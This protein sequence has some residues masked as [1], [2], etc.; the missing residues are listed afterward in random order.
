MA[1]K[2]RDD[3]ED[4]TEDEEGAAVLSPDDRFF[5]RKTFRGGTENSSKSLDETLYSDPHE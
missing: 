2:E 1:E 5:E 4:E 3:R